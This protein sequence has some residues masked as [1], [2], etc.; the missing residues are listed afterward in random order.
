MDLD[1][2]AGPLAASPSPAPFIDIVRR[3]A[4]RGRG[5]REEGAASARA[6]RAVGA[7]PLGAADNEFCTEFCTELLS[8]GMSIMPLRSLRRRCQRRRRTRTTSPASWRRWCGAGCALPLASPGAAA[9]CLPA[10]ERAPPAPRGSFEHRHALLR[11]L[12]LAL[13]LDPTAPPTDKQTING[14]I[15]LA[16]IVLFLVCRTF[17]RQYQLRS[18]R[19]NGRVGRVLASHLASRASHVGPDRPSPLSRLDQVLDHVTIKPPPLPKGVG[20]LFGWIIPTLTTSDTWLLHSAGLDAL[21]LQKSQTLCLQLFLPIS[22]I[23]CCLREC[24]DRAW[25]VALCR[26]AAAL[27]RAAEK[28]PTA[29]GTS[30]TW[31]TPKPG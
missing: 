8:L 31:P 30:L 21:V 10:Q 25:P 28:D 14:F 29:A 3:E 9:C 16:C 19:L 2:G 18:V 4:S 20:K 27:C 26:A 24:R 6:A 13:I 23:G 1:A 7:Q 17:T 11:R 5:G 12:P 15:G 22:A